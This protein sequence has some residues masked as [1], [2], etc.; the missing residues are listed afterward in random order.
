MDSAFDRLL[1]DENPDAIIVTTPSTMVV[2]WNRGAES[3]YGYSRDE[4]LG[5]RLPDLIVTGIT[6]SEVER[7]VEGAIRAGYVTG[8]GV[9]RRKDG[10]TFP[11]HLAVGEMTEGGRRMFTGMMRDLSDLR[12]AESEAARQRAKADEELRRG[13]PMD[14]LD[15]EDIVAI[16][17][18][19]LVSFVN[20][21]IGLTLDEH[22]GSVDVDHVAA[23]FRVI[24][25]EILAL[26]HA[27]QPPPGH[28]T[29][30]GEPMA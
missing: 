11:V 14:A 2:Y 13:D 6:E 4:A 7:L 1:L 8:E 27:V 17:Q 22:A 24:L 3:M 9:R 16:E 5:R 28:S 30:R 26:S 29:V 10:S 18:P 23:V 21:H 25:I 12:R 20:E 15:S 19:A